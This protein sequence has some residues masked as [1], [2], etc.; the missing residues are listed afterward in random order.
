MRF[1]EK[2]VVITGGAAGIGAAT[3]RRFAAEGAAVAIWDVDADRGNA[4][5]DDLRAKGAKIV[6]VS[7]DTSVASAVSAAVEQTLKAMGRIDILVN[8]AGI[9]RDATLLKMSE[10]QWDQV[11]GINL[12][13]VFHCTHAIAPLMVA[14]GFGRILN[15]SSVV[16]LYGNFGQTNYAATKAGV[17]AMTKVWAKELGRKGVTVNAVAPGFIATEMVQ[18]MPEEVLSGMKD[19]VP[20]KRLG[21]PE[22]IAGVYAFLA[23]DEAAYINGAVISIDGGIT[24]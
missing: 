21:T 24:L 9:T 22:E 13:G 5:A 14:N 19:K 8:N 23:S 10:A 17:I 15:A 4:L 1:Q 11:I 6:F 16:G 2:T 18:A 7:C 3:A 12:S 20:L